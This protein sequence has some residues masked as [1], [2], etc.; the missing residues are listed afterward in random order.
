MVPSTYQP[1]VFST[2]ADLSGLAAIM[3]QGFTSSVPRTEPAKFS[4][5]KDVADKLGASGQRAMDQSDEN[6]VMSQPRRLNE[7]KLFPPASNFNNLASI[8]PTVAG[9]LDG[10]TAVLDRKKKVAAE[11]ALKKQMREIETQT[12]DV[13]PATPIRIGQE[14]ESKPNELI[15]SNGK[16]KILN[17]VRNIMVDDTARNKRSIEK[18]KAEQAAKASQKEV[19]PYVELTKAGKPKATKRNIEMFTQPR[20]I[21]PRPQNRA[22]SV[23]VFNQPSTVRSEMSYF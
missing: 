2:P 1:P 22:E 14:V 11:D 15:G 6:V 10:L 16:K 9:A 4:E 13:E 7:E 23:S 20:A 3:R 21:S 18:Q 17:P 19:G 5:I 8:L 12:V